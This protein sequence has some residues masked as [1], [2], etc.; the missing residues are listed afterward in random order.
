MLLL[1]RPMNY[2][3]DCF[4]PSTRN[5]KILTTILSQYFKFV[6]SN[7]IRTRN[8]I[9]VDC[10]D[11]LFSCNSLCYYKLFSRFLVNAL[12]TDRSA[13]RYQTYVIKM[14]ITILTTTIISLRDAGFWKFD[15]LN[16]DQRL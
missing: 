16:S 9:I 15:F 1:R 4:I 3:E 13:Y 11:L 6:S 10:V 5:T 12:I 8:N 2:N 7:T 14:M